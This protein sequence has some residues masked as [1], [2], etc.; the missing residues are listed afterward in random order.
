MEKISSFAARREL[1][2]VG[3]RNKLKINAIYENV[4]N[5][6]RDEIAVLNHI[7]SMIQNK[8]ANWTK[9]LN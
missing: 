7:Q 5:G 4:R 1:L 3:D 2:F 9:L 6:H 8:D